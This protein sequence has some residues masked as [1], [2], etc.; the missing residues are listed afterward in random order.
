MS[1]MICLNPNILVIIELPSVLFL[2]CLVPIWV[3]S[4]VA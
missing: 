3:S 4:G 1:K 2:L